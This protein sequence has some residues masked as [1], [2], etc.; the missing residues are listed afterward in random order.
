MKPKRL[1][2][3]KINPNNYLSKVYREMKTYPI[4]IN[5]NLKVNKWMKNLKYKNLVN[6]KNR[7]KS[8]TKINYKIIINNF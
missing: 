3:N 5:L 4:K 6:H 8:I 2:K 7:Y 1:N